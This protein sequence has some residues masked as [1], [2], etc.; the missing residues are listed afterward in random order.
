MSQI[1]LAKASHTCFKCDIYIWSGFLILFDRGFY[2]W[3][4]YRL[5]SYGLVSCRLFFSSSSSTPSTGLDS[6]DIIASNEM[7][8]TPFRRPPPP[9][10]PL[11]PPLP[12][13]STSY[14]SSYSEYWLIATFIS[15]SL[16]HEEN[17]NSSFTPLSAFILLTFL[18]RGKK[19]AKKSHWA[20]GNILN[21]VHSVQ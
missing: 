1:W 12:P 16:R 18:W 5:V 13:C 19:R 2:I 9:S 14:A 6:E 21:S 7:V 4:E 8:P 10:P 15:A 17:V 3:H 11:L 20:I